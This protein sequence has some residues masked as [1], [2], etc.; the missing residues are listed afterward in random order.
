MLWCWASSFFHSSVPPFFFF[1]T[2][3][4][5]FRCCLLLLPDISA[6]VLTLSSFSRYFCWT[7][8]GEYFGHNDLG[9]H[10][11]EAWRYELK[12]GHGH[13]LK[14][15]AFAS[16]PQCLI[17]SVPH[18][19]WSSNSTSRIKAVGCFPGGLSKRQ[20]Q[21]LIFCS[22]VFMESILTELSLPQQ[23]NKPVA[24]LY[25]LSA[26]LIVMQE[27]DSLRRMSWL[28]AET[29]WS[30]S[31]PYCTSYDGNYAYS[32]CLGHVNFTGTL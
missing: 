29:S 8:T 32:L 22:Y 7:V 30:V 31:G 18:S 14:L 4:L 20:Y 2:F 1:Q 21:L 23:P 5:L 11:W 16:L 28:F 3:L 15:F 26:V 25:H 12:R 13:A 17:T 24:S 19:K 9:T 6:V 10:A 27:K